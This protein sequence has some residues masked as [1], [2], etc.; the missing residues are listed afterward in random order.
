LAPPSGLGLGLGWELL[1]GKE[2]GQ[3]LGIP[4]EKLLVMP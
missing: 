1:M 3:L 2:L 4:L